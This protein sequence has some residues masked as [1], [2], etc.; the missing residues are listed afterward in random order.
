MWPALSAIEDIQAE[1][2]S[3]ERSINDRGRE[4]EDVSAAYQKDIE[5]FEMLL[6]VV[7]LAPDTTDPT[8]GREGQGHRRPPSLR[9]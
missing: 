7:E 1:I 6:E 8:A 2:E 3:T 9:D 5:R 4:I